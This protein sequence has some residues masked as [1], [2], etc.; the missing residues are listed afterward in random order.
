MPA[1]R[2]ACWSFHTI[3]TRYRQRLGDFAVAHNDVAMC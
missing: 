1:L 3:K 2:G